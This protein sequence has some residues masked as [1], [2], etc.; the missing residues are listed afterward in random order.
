MSRPFSVNSGSADDFQ[1]SVGCGLRRNARQIRGTAV[2]GLALLSWPWTALT[3]AY[4]RPAGASS[5]VFAITRSTGSALTSRG[6][7]GRTHR[8][9]PSRR[10][11][12]NRPRHFDTMS[13]DTPSGERD[14]PDRPTL[15]RTATRCAIAPPAPERSSAVLAATSQAHWLISCT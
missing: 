1:V 3:S 14:L 7:P 9:E 5:S 12:R 2:W 11:R 6:R 15:R 8:T 4:P 10:F 13:R